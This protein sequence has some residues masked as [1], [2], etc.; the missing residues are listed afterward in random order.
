MSDLRLR[1]K[2]I[3]YDQ[4]GFPHVVDI[5]NESRIGWLEGQPFQPWDIPADE[6]DKE[7]LFERFENE[8]NIVIPK[9]E[10]EKIQTVGDVIDYI[11]ANI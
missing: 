7:F 5:R 11:I 3:I 1:V 10:F 9:S 8:F 6:L 4:I 2:H